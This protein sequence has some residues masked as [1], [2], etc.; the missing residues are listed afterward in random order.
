MSLN[1]ITKERG[2]FDI[3]NEEPFKNDCI[4]VLDNHIRKLQS[5]GAVPGCRSIMTDEDLRCMFEFV[6]GKNGPKFHF[7]KMFL[8]VFPLIGNRGQEGLRRIR[9][10]DFVLKSCTIMKCT[11]ITAL[12]LRGLSVT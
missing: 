3:I 11:E 8:L 5:D 1:R 6:N 2:G 9:S 4:N 12:P 10:T 7:W